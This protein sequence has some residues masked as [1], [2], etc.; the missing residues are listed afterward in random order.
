MVSGTHYDVVVIGSGF[1]GS[2]TALPAD[3]EGLPG[4]DARGWPP[5][6]RRRAAAD[7]LGAAQ[8]PMGAAALLS[9]QSAGPRAA[10]RG[11]PGRR[12]VGGGS[13]VY[14]NVLYE[15]RSQAFYRDRQWAHTTDW[16]EELAPYYDQAKRVL[17]VVQNPTMTPSDHVIRRVAEEIGAGDT[18]ASAPVAVFFESGDATSAAP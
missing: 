2:V 5:L 18:F 11:R 8:V 13:L 14:G 16:R 9:G 10:R 4:R 12:R 7:L 17:G 1:G 3:R 15:P 6:R